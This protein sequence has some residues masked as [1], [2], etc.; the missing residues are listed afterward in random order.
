VL[1]CGI[2]N[3]HEKDTCLNEIVLRPQILIINLD[4]IVNTAGQS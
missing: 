1:R 2:L 4:A 3:A